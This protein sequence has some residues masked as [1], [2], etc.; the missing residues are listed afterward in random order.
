[1]TLVSRICVATVLM[2]SVCLTAVSP[3]KELDAG[4]S[5]A[6]RW[7]DEGN[8]E[9]CEGFKVMN[10]GERRAFVSGLTQGWVMALDILNALGEKAAVPRE[11]L[12]ENDRCSDRLR[13]VRSPMAGVT[14]GE[15]VK[16][17]EIQCER[18][19]MASSSASYAWWKALGELQDE[20]R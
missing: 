11:I 9:T 2:F 20:K 4:P 16:R 8:R 6:Q 5:D 18:A 19:Q 7:F 12:D 3:A 17:T 15:L 1:M 14:M 10:S 13:A